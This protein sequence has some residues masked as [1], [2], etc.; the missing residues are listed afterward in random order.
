MPLPQFYNEYSDFKRQAKE[1][2]SR[3]TLLA[4]LLNE[5]IVSSA[6]FAE[7]ISIL[8]A[9]SFATNF[10]P[11]QSWYDIFLPT[12]DGQNGL[13]EGQDVISLLV[14]DIMAI[15]E[16]DPACTNLVQAFLYFKGE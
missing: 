16:R 9:S 8:L 3:E 5:V 6:N 15:Q 4:P 14:N 13:Y 11:R 1:I 10:I 7:A 2:S 12:F